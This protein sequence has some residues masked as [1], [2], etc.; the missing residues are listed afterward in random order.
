[1]LHLISCLPGFE[2]LIRLKPNH[3][4]FVFT[5]AIL[6]VFFVIN[7]T[8]LYGQSV[9]TFNGDG[10]WS[11]SSNW[12]NKS[13]PDVVLPNGSTIVISPIA[14]GKCILNVRQIISAGGQLTVSAGANFEV[15][16]D[17]SV[18]NN[19]TFTD[20]RDGQVYPIIQAGSQIW[21]GKNLNYADSSSFCN[22]S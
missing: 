16:G 1:K 7:H 6:I 3:M 4:K 20:P 22:D 13:V 18:F 21:M 10:N 2:I 15:A 5:S 9:Y 19:G 12:L 11:D 14:N 8:C 17:I